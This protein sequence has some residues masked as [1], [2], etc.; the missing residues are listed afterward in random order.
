MAN[1]ELYFKYA[2]VL[3]HFKQIMDAESI[4]Y[5]ALEMNPSY[6]DQ[7]LSICPEAVHHPAIMDLL[8]NYN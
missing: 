7:F 2:A 1:R 6:K 8:E 4:L 5:I 3:I